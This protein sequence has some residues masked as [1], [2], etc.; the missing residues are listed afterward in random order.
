MMATIES[1]DTVD[2]VTEFT[3]LKLY[4]HL[5]HLPYDTVEQLADA[6]GSGVTLTSCVG[7]N[8]LAYA[9]CKQHKAIQSKKDTGENAHIDKIG[10]VGPM[11]PR[12][13][14]GNHYMIHF[15]DHISN[16]VRAFL[17]KNKVEATKKFE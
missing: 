4:N 11:T 16:Y 5:G 10:G 8:C 2:A 12:H 7:L 9:Q 15:V 1:A 13:R 17:T 14:H 6:P 3:L